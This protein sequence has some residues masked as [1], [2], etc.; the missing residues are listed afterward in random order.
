MED[1]Y[2]LSICMILS[3]IVAWTIFFPSDLTAH[4]DWERKNIAP[5]T[6]MAID[7]MQ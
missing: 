7:A 3:N 1:L 6:R 2:T 4:K 5:N